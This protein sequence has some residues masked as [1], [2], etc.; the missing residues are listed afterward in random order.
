MDA[1]AIAIGGRLL[2]AKD[3]RIGELEAALGRLVEAKDEKD[4]NGE[5]PRYRELK[6]GAWERARALLGR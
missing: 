1:A 2:D 5:T 4:A 6:A 3:K